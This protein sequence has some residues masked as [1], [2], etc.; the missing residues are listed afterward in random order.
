LSFKDTEELNM[1]L[2]MYDANDVHPVQYHFD[3]RFKERLALPDPNQCN[4]AKLH[5][6]RNRTEENH[7]TD[8]GLLKTDGA[9]FL[10]ASIIE[11][12]NTKYIATQH[13]LPST[14]IDFW[15]MVLVEKPCA[16]IMLNK[17]DFDQAQKVGIE[18]ELVQYW[19]GDTNTGFVDALYLEDT[20]TGGVVKVSVVDDL[21]HKI[22]ELV[23]DITTNSNKLYSPKT[24]AS[25]ITDCPES[26][27]PMIPADPTT[28]VT[29][30][31]STQSP[32]LPLVVPDEPD[33]P[34]PPSSPLPPTSPPCSTTY[35]RPHYNSNSHRGIECSKLR[36]A[37]QGMEHDVWHIRCSS[38]KDQDAPDLDMFMELWKLVGEKLA[39]H[40]HNPGQKH[41]LVVH[42]TGGVGRTGT[43]ITIDIAGQEL[44]ARME[45][46]STEEF[47][48][49]RIIQFLRSKRMNMVGSV[50][51]YV[52]C[53][54]AALKV[55]AES[56]LLA[57]KPAK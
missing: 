9:E 44:K 12:K 25:P 42:C 30:A 39:D 49:E 3:S 21:H 18:N 46:N 5:A 40:S 57:D 7:P 1:L 10:N 38:W 2:Q 54:R 52:F 8:E 27:P 6:K 28:L 56:A 36:V 43:F 24:T 35:H 31:P 22:E 53:H 17:Y 34:S 26:P 32:S 19:P 50:P 14:M 20:T 41:K 13:P 55:L 4:I 47:S 45:Q 37:Y 15:K 51:Q 16:I 33:I 29:P 11:G 48:V 23:G